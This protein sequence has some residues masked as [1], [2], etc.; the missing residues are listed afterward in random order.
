MEVGVSRLL[1]LR[2][3]T[4]TKSSVPFLSSSKRRNKHQDANKLGKHANLST[5]SCQTEKK[6]IN[7]TVQTKSHLPAFGNL[8][9]FR[10]KIAVSDVNGDYL[11]EDV[12][13]RSWDLA[14]GII[15]LLGDNNQGK[16]ICFLCP[17]G[18]THVITSWACWMSGNVAVPLCPGSDQARLEHLMMDSSCS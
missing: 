12:Y 5:Q 10:S 16:R 6:F 3:V 1:T 15:G 18:L 11:Y 2:G 7:E 13:L 14:K 17:S 8:E 9:L 4:A